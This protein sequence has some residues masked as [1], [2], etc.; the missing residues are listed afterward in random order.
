MLRADAEEF[1]D[2]SLGT[3]TCLMFSPSQV[4]KVLRKNR[5]GVYHNDYKFSNIFVWANIA[6]PGQT[7]SLF[8]I[9]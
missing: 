7:S 6:Y 4:S 9:P 5:E 3:D 1:I 8:P 2:K